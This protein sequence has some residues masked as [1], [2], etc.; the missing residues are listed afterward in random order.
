MRLDEEKKLK[1]AVS[2]GYDSEKVKTFSV[3]LDEHF[4]WFNN[5]EKINETVVFDL[6]GLKL[7]AD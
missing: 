1:I 6:N 5:G 4:S 2:K 7:V 3:R